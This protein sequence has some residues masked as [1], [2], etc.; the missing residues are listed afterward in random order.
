MSTKSPS[1][2][3]SPR[4]S[5]SRL[6]LYNITQ[7]FIRAQRIKK[8]KTIVSSSGPTPITHPTLSQ[9]VGY[10]KLP[11]SHEDEF[12]CSNGVDVP[13]LLRAT[14]S[15]LLEKA[16]ILGAHILVEERYITPHYSPPIFPHHDCSQLGSLHYPPEGPQD[17]SIQS[18]GWILQ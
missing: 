5:S 17:W 13:K 7:A 8:S 11:V 16:Q 2:P 10:S 12:I 9:A 18:Q 6:S 4:I 1:P 14:R 3:T 15:T